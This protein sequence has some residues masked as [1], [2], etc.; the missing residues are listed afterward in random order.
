MIINLQTNCSIKETPTVEQFKT[1]LTA[2]QNLT[3]PSKK[4]QEITIQITDS[5]EIQQ[6]NKDYR[7]IDKPTNILSFEFEEIVEIPD[8]KTKYIGDLVIANDI[9]KKEAKMQNKKISNHWA[10]LTI[11]G[12]LHLLGFDHIDDK[13]ADN[14]EALEVK[15]LNSI[16]ISNP[17]L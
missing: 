8:L 10:H 11:H 4:Q 12:F 1:W 13:E 9:V 6:L 15:I 17:Y 5:K 14:M 7:G 16:N 3:A 2:A